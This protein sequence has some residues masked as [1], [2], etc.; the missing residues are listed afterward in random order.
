MFLN[1]KNRSWCLS[2]GDDLKLTLLR[3]DLVIIRAVAKRRYDTLKERI[4]KI[5][6]SPV[7][8]AKESLIALGDTTYYS[9]EEGNNLGAL[10]L[11]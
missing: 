8:I 1:G 5:F 9:R 6:Q 3:K 4:L 2:T 10:R 7:I 11:G